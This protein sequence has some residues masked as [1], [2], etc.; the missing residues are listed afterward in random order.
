MQEKK[1]TMLFARA[2]NAAVPEFGRQ[3]VCLPVRHEVRMKLVPCLLVLVWLLLFQC[4]AL[5]M[6]K[7][8]RSGVG[9]TLPMCV[10]C[11]PAHASVAMFQSP[12]R[13]RA[14]SCFMTSHGEDKLA[15]A[16]VLMYWTEIIYY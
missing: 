14:F 2:P 13:Y 4:R 6:M 5:R 10:A 8:G 16:R 7:V 11:G 3:S 9:F 1:T 15:L 12:C